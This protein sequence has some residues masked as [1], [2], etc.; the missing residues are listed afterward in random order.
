MRSM[1]RWR[2]RDQRIGVPAA[3]AAPAE[4]VAP[5]SRTGPA[6]A[7][8]GRGRAGPVLA[9]RRRAPLA[10]RNAVLA[11]VLGDPSD[12]ARRAWLARL[13]EYARADGVAPPPADRL[14]RRF[15]GLDRA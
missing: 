14:V 4:A 12:D 7:G 6:P 3:A 8:W 2:P 11:R 10:A 15:A 1:R 13:D 5:S 9:D